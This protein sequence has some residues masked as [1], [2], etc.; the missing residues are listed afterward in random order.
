MGT[1]L[2]PG[3]QARGSG[4]CRHAPSPITREQEQH[5]SESDLPPDR[6]VDPPRTLEPAVAV[7]QIPTD[8]TGDDEEQAAER[9]RNHTLVFP[10]RTSGPRA[11]VK[12][13]TDH[14]GRDYQREQRDELVVHGATIPDALRL[15]GAPQRTDED[16]AG[17][18]ANERPGD[19]DRREVVDRQHSRNKKP[20]EKRAG[21]CA[22]NPGMAE[23][24]QNTFG[25]GRHE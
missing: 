25:S 14:Y 24:L 23:R 8:E 7:F 20:A 18:E 16:G 2:L 4:A 13:S 19:N 6:A 10:A 3:V 12:P 15:L 1:P 5:G 9:R 22:G 11:A 17:D 21:T